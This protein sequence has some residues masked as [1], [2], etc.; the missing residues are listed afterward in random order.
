MNARQMAPTFIFNC[1]PSCTKGRGLLYRSQIAIIALARSTT[2]MNIP[3]HLVLWITLRYLSCKLRGS[4]DLSL[5]WD[6]GYRAIK[7][8][9]VLQGRIIQHDPPYSIKHFGIQPVEQQWIV[10]SVLL[11]NWAG[12]WRMFR[13]SRWRSHTTV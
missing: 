13:A 9:R 2:R 6:Y 12:P 1:S 11:S 8:S 10:N 3:F 5:L 7:G 4:L